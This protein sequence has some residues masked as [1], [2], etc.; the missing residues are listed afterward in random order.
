MK[1]LVLCVSN[2]VKFSF[3]CMLTAGHKIPLNIVDEECAQVKSA[4]LLSF[5]TVFMLK[6]TRLIS[7][8]HRF[9]LGGL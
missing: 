4:V 9:L 5:R 8:H 7:L 6:H 1:V 2:A 3:I